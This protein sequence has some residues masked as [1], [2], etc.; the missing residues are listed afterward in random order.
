MKVNIPC[1]TNNGGCLPDRSRL[2]VLLVF[3]AVFQ[4]LVSSCS[5]RLYRDIKRE[6][7]VS[8]AESGDL[9][10]FLDSDVE[11]S[12]DTREAT[13][14]MIIQTARGYL[15]VPHCMGGSTGKCMDCSG[16]LVR[17]FATHGIQLPHNSEE[18]ARYGK[19]I[20]DGSRLKT[21]DLVFFIRTYRTKQFITHSGIYTGDGL[22]IHTSSSKGVIITS[23]NDPWWRKRYIFGT[24]IFD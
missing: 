24:R 5:A 8:R 2:I 12:L 3:L 10:S 11:K 16:L 7:P 6:N 18:Q 20:G 1:N 4:L 19:I 13:P 21:G 23:I 15:G 17:V 22:F 9:R 14:E